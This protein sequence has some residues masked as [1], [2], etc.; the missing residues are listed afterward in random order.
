LNHQQ[1]LSSHIYVHFL[2]TIYSL[3][4]HCLCTAYSLPTHLLTVYLLPIHCL[5]TAN[6]RCE[7]CIT[8]KSSQPIHRLFTAYSSPIHCL[9]TLF[10]AYSMP[11][12]SLCYSIRSPIRLPISLAHSTIQP[13]VTVCDDNFPFLSTLTSVLFPRHL[14]CSHSTSGSIPERLFNK[15]RWL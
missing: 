4:V 12:Q 1:V 5:F 11:V 15:S 9:F 7:L 6:T 13:P 2:F 10:T 8:D 3:P 14:L